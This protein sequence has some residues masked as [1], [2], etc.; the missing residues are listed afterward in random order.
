MQ[1]LVALMQ[2]PRYGKYT[3]SKWYPTIN[4]NIA[5]GIYMNILK[6]DISGY[7]EF[8]GMRL[9]SHSLGRNRAKSARGG[10]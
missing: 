2:Y 6:F 1:I 9:G 4:I 8:T 10:P 5:P 7:I 3:L